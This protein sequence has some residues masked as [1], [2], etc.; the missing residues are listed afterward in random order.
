M[1]VKGYPDSGVVTPHVSFLALDSLP[2]EA[3]ENIQNFTDFGMYG[4]YGFY[5]SISL[6]RQR[7]NPQYLALDQGMTLIA[8]A[9]YLKG[10]T[11]QKR[12]HADS[13]GKKA[14]EIMAKES[15]FKG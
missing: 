4:D 1:A 9:N 6:R 11:I 12:F 14:A 15:F 5:D 2:K 7:V 8:I 13:V 10:G 3:L